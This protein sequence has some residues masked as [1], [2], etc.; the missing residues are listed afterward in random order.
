[1]KWVASVCAVAG[2]LLAAPIAQAQAQ[3]SFDQ[4]GV[5]FVH[6]FVGT[7]AQF[8]SQKLRFMSNGYPER[9][10]DAI[11]YDSTFATESR[12]QVHARIDGLIAELKQRTG[13]PKVDLLGHSLGTSVLQEYL[14]SSAERAANVARYVNIDGSQAE[15]LPGGVPTLAIWA[16]RGEPG[17]RIAGATN[18]TLPNQTHVEAATSAEAFVEYHKFFTG[19]APAHGIVPQAG[20]ITIAGR[21]LHFPVNRGVVGSTLAIWE[22]DGATGQRKGSAPLTSIAIGDS[23]N[24]GPVEVTAG[25]HYEFE[26]T[27]PGAPAHHHYYEPFVRSDHLV[28]LLESDVLA[29]GGERG[30]RHA[31]AVILRYKELWGDQPGQNDVLSINGTSVCTA[32]LCPITKRVNAFFFSDRRMDGQTDL[33]QPDP[34]YSAL[35]FVTGA[36]LFAPAAIPPAGRTTVELKARGGGPARAV[37]MPN[38]ASLTDVATVQLNDFERTDGTAPCLRPSSVAFKLHRVRGAR[39]VRVEAFVNGRRA[40]RTSGRDIYR[41]ILRRLPRDGRMSVRIVATHNTGSKVVSARTWNGCT[42]GKPRVRRIP[43]PR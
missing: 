43:R 3:S 26:V 6:G 23:G 38:F 33:S 22:V 12:S 42:K 35:P 37:H 24:W 4:N 15:A 13:R 20:Q 8:E 31:A 34:V 41:I 11:D 2:L 5:L 14:N 36:D 17:R 40:L 39:V 9:W 21:V 29:N 28:R 7:G 1:M 10:V 25:R 32:V 18:V 30:P 16:G 27:R 19:R